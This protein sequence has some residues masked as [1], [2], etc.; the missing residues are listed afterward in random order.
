MHE[1]SCEEYDVVQGKLSDV[2]N[3]K[4]ERGRFDCTVQGRKTYAV[5]GSNMN[6]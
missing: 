4:T 1:E 3:I 6:D 2:T 5:A